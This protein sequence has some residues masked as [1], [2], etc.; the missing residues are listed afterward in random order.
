MKVVAFVPIKFRSQRLENKN[1]LPLGKFPLCWYIFET[2]K[3]VKNIDEIYVYCS[4]DRI[5]KYIPNNI[6]FLKRPDEL[7]SNETKG[8]DIYTNFINTIEA[9]VYVLAHATSPFIRSFSVQKGLDSILNHGHDSAFSVQKM[10]TY[11]WYQNKPLNYELEN[12]VRTQD[13]DSVLLETSAFYIFKKEILQNGR[14]IGNNPFQVITD[15]IESVDIDEMDDYRLA[16]AIIT[17][18]D[19]TYSFDNRLQNHKNPFNRNIKMIVMDFDGTLSTGLCHID[20]LRHDTNNNQIESGI[21]GH[22]R[23]TTDQYINMSK[24]YNSKDGFMIKELAKKGIIFVIISGA[25]M[26]F[27]TWKAKNL[28][29]K[30]IYGNIDNKKKLIKKILSIEEMRGEKIDLTSEVAYIGDDNNDIDIGESVAIFGCPNNSSKK[31][32]QKSQ[33]ISPYNGGQGAVRDFLEYLF[34]D[35]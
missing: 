21:I 2:L 4:D 30:Y 3:Q 29:I 18:Y 16:Q 11:G 20:S 32:K 34:P 27:F 1:I 26:D 5:V 35:V 12:V 15:R 8:L 22:N 23:D 24:C 14:R 25:N 10:Q 31:V 6:K 28:G 19:F 33:Y 17:S 9:D 13:L 7:D